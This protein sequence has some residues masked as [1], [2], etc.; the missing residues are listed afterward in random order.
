LIGLVGAALL[1]PLL[2]CATEDVGVSTTYDPLTRFPTEATY[3]WDEAANLRPE[4]PQLAGSDFDA[5]FHEVVD[6]ELGA[7]GYRVTSSGSPD[8]RLSYE[9][10]IHTWTGPERSA[11]VGSLS[12]LL[13]DRR[14]RHRVWTGFAR[15]DVLVGLTPEERKERLRLALSRMLEHFPPAQ[16][17]EE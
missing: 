12:L 16:R 10:R 6:Q 5:L 4:D 14:S 1:I 2:G 13:T 15:A 17:G 11:A 8:Y 3:A 7:R 9:L